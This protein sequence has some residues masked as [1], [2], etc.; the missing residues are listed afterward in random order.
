MR[1]AG[2]AAL[3]VVSGSVSAL[4]VSLPVVLTDHSPANRCSASNGVLVASAA[5][6]K[7][8][9]VRVPIGGG[10]RSY[11]I[12]L[13]DG[14]WRIAATLPDC[15]SVAR[16]WSPALGGTP[17]SIDLFGAAEV[18]GTFTAAPKDR[19]SR[20]T[21][22]VQRG[23]DGTEPVEPLDC[24]LDFPSWRC[25]VP[26]N[27]VMDVRL[28]PEGFAPVH[29]WSVV[30][31]PGAKQE[32]EPQPLVAGASLGG[33]V[34]SSDGHLLAG[35]TISLSPLD[36]QHTGLR[37][38]EAK[39]NTK[40][41]F[42]FGGV[43]PGEHRLVARSDG[44]SP[45]VVPV[46]TMRPNEA[47]T[48]PRLLT[49]LPLATLDVALDP[50]V[51][52]DGK[53]WTV[54]AWERVPLVA[55]ATDPAVRR[56]ATDDGRWTA[57]NL[58]ADVYRLAIE[59][60]SGSVFDDRT[61]D[62]TNGSGAILPISIHSLPV[63]GRLTVGDEPLQARIRFTN[64]GGKSLWASSDV[65]GYFDVPFPA[66]GDWQ[67][68]VYVSGTAGAKVRAKSVHLDAAD[69]PALLEIRLP[70][71]RLHGTV[72]T[73]EG[74]A[75]KAAVHVVADGKPLAQQVTGDD[76]KFDFLG[77][78][79]SS[80]AVSA[81]AKEGV[82]KTPATIDLHDRATIDL[83]LTVDPYRTL[84]GVVVTPAGQAASGALVRL[85]F[86]GGSSWTD[87]DADVEG[88]FDYAVPGSTSDAMVLVLTH[89]WPAALARLRLGGDSGPVTI[90]L[91]AQGGRLHVRGKGYVV[92]RD[93]VVPFPLLLL[94]YDGTESG[95]WLE[96]G[97][98][99]ICPAPTISDAC[100]QVL[101]AAG[102]R[103]G[104][105]MLAPAEKGPR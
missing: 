28:E 64:G 36:P 76:G 33:R 58:R 17:V 61:I 65:D 105:D 82:T 85:S 29:Y 48:M 100:R 32:L 62:L 19:P 20:M 84:R 101:L 8:A 57:K 56:A 15:W 79:R 16:D 27:V 38:A 97:S 104:V 9:E 46:V 2:I 21:G 5:D 96:P 102:A 47:V 99:A 22:S 6:G 42:Q 50:P 75:V 40:G 26:A 30:A 86:D 70:G 71:G 68:I 98:Y 4:A 52:P 90:A 91:G 51:A 7:S 87:I 83:E 103:T 44:L 72:V 1:V 3:L 43:A 81:E 23:A 59:D 31:A 37:R 13:P 69:R 39:S 55:G 78:D 74:K 88:R 25:S 54:T 14:G 41:F 18:R 93:A 73:S 80:F 67:P 12:E 89:S 45:A 35:A 24:V 10:Q 77:L 94:P 49:L 63:R 66:P 11:S 53:H 60:S 92:A 34:Q 95:A